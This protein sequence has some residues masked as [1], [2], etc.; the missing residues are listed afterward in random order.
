M[1]ALGA[2][3][4]VLALLGGALLE[5]VHPVTDAL[6]VAV[7]VFVRSLLV[8]LTL[9][10]TLLLA[11]LAGWRIELAPLPVAA[12]PTAAP[13]AAP[14]P[15]PVTDADLTDATATAEAAVSTPAPARTRTQAALAGAIILFGYWFFTT[16]YIVLFGSS[17]G[18]IGAQN[19]GS[20]LNF[21][22]SH[23]ILGVVYVGLGAGFASLGSRAAAARR[24]MRNLTQLASAPPTSP[25]STTGRLS[26][27]PATTS[28]ASMPPSE[29]VEAPSDEDERA[30][31]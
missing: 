5:P 17:I 7:A 25:T 22:L 31:P 26:Q 24:L 1:G 28:S 27:T 3:L 4:G 13:T 23:V 6:S 10:I 19:G 11:Y 2:V 20:P 16:L 29:P 21:T 8:L 12:A 9:A 30:Q 15:A 18:G 14:A